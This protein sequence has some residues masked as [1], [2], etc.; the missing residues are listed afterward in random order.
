MIARI[1]LADDHKMMR[2]ALK[3]LLSS[4]EDIVVVAEADDG[5]EV[6]EKMDD[7]FPDIVIMDVNMPNMNGIETTKQLIAKQA[8]VKVI[9]LSAFPDKRF[10]LGMLE[11]GAVGYIVKAE[12][13]D[14][15]FRA[16][17]VVMN[18]G[19]YIC[20]MISASLDVAGKEKLKY[21]LSSR[22]QEVLVL[23]AH[24]LHSSQIGEQLGISPATV[25]VHRRNIM[26]KVGVRGIAELTKY[27]IREGLVTV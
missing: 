19:T 25:E 5:N 2:Q 6:L 3:A 24:G 14:E 13:G 27:A 20:P 4:N 12:A 21:S 10:V 1:L 23:L 9:G 8:N 26:R 16:I 7:A 11:A 17:H 18:G 15:L 22:E